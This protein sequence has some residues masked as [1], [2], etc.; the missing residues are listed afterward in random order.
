LKKFNVRRLVLKIA[1]RRTSA[2]DALSA[3]SR[4]ASSKVENNAYEHL[5]NPATL[6][7]NYQG[8]IFRRR[9]KPLNP[10]QANVEL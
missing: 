2:S 10:V 4:S 5:N 1:G 8:G 6:P 3:G 7:G 9:T